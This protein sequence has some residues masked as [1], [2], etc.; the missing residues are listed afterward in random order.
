MK[1]NLI[2]DR[3]RDRVVEISREQPTLT[4]VVHINVGEC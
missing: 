3:D 4:S 1:E 2:G